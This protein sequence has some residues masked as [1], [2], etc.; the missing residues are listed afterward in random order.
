MARRTDDHHAGSNKAEKRDLTRFQKSLLKEANRTITLRSDGHA[1]EATLEEAVIRKLFQVATSGSPHALGHVLRN[2]NDAQMLNQALIREEVAKGKQIKQWLQQRLDRAVREGADPVWV[3]PHP[4]DIVIDEDEGW[5]VRG[6]VDVDELKS[7]RHQVTMRDILLLQSVLDERLSDAPRLEESDGPA[8]ETAGST[9]QVF[10]NL[11]NNN[12]PKRFQLSAAGVVLEI[13]RFQRLT[14]R[15]L[16]KTTHLAWAAIGQPKPRGATL[17]P[18]SEAGPRIERTMRVIND[19]LGQLKPGTL[20][21]ERDIV[22]R[23]S[24]ML[25]R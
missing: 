16:L 2:I 3:I 5:S 15:E 25:Q 14:K 11:L 24:E 23:L 9:S 17:P 20:I 19:A 21:S 18:W 22:E 6:P 4:D 8:V 13:M 7:I 12:L 10:A 1:Q